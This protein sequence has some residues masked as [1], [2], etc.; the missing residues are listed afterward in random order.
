M[1]REGN[2]TK[3]ITLVVSDLKLQ[4][5]SN[6]WLYQLKRDGKVYKEKGKEWFRADELE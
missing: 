6:R 1:V 4:P 5:K 3:E 2:F